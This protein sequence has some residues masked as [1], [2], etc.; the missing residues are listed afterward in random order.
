ML[1]QVKTLFPDNLYLNLY[2]SSIDASLFCKTLRFS[3]WFYSTAIEENYYSLYD[4]NLLF[5]HT[6]PSLFNFSTVQHI[7]AHTLR[8]SVF[9]WRFHFQITGLG[10]K[11]VDVKPTFIEFS[12][13]FSHN[14]IYYFK[15]NIFAVRTARQKQSFKLFGLDLCASVLIVGLIKRLKAP[16]IYKGKGLRFYREKLKLRKREKFSR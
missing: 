5:I 9:K 8:S 4:S 7:V 10:F 11:L 1:Y 13:G 14:L 12:L 15:E 3:F 16:D 6:K 2:S